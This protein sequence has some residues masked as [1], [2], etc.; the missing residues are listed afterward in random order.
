[1]FSSM[2]LKETLISFKHLL[3]E[4]VFDAYLSQE[5]AEET[6]GLL[7]NLCFVQFHGM[8]MGGA[9]TLLQGVMGINLGHSYV[10]KVYNNLLMWGLR[11]L[12]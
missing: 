5:Q 3:A 1:M 7:R 11:F 4:D 8:Q 10:Y 9:R 2:E 6:S 12:L